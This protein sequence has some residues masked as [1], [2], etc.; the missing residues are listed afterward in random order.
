M[1]APGAE[2]VWRQLL[3]LHLDHPDQQVAEQA[4]AALAAGE[5]ADTGATAVS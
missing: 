3:R 4:A 5:L 1:Q 2:P